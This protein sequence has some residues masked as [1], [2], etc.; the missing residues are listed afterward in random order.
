VGHAR[1]KAVEAITIETGRFVMR[2]LE[3][4]DASERYASWF[5][6]PEVQR[7]IAA[8]GTAPS[9]AALREYIAERC[10]RDDILFLGIHTRPTGTHIG[11]VKFEPVDSAAGRAVLGIMI[12]DPA[13][14]GRG[15]AAEAIVAANHWLAAHRGIREVVLGVARDNAGAKRAYEKAGFV[16]TPRDDNDPRDWIRMVW[17]AAS[18]AA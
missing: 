9:V 5:V 7:Y 15:A 17:R 16:V 8:A 3:P 11:N 1:L 2:P 14:R 18:A 10:D 12:G 13:W 4:R 6:D